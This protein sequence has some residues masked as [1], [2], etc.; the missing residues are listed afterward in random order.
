MQRLLLAL[1]L[2]AVAVFATASLINAADYLLWPVGP[3]PLGNLLTAAGMVAPALA[4]WLYAG[5]RR[6]LRG[7]C[8]LF[9]WLTLACAVTSLLAPVMVA[10]V[11]LVDVLR[12]KAS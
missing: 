7:Y 9:I 2:V 3:F 5:D 4:A 10:I 6:W 1:A 12:R 11:R 8:V